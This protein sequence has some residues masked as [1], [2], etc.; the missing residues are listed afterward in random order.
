MNE[1]QTARAEALRPL[2]KNM[3]PAQAQEI[4]EAYYRI[5]ENLRP[6]VTALEAADL[7]NGGPEGPLLEEHYIFCQL[8]EKIDESA[9]GAVL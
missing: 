1:S 5:A 3:D 7:D 6:L 9:L 2:F 8:L 4:R